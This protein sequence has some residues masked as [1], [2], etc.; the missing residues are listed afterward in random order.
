VQIDT[1][2]TVGT[3]PVDTMVTVGHPHLSDTTTMTV[4][5]VTVMTVV[6]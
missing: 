2:M 4:T 1:M 5:V 6:H 3:V